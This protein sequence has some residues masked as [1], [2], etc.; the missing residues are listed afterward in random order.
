MLEQ[1]PSQNEPLKPPSNRRVSTRSHNSS[2]Q[3]SLQ[4]RSDQINL[5]GNDHNDDQATNTFAQLRPYLTAS[6]NTRDN[7]SPIIRHQHERL[8][9]TY[10]SKI[11][12]TDEDSKICNVFKD[13]SIEINIQGCNLNRNNDECEDPVTLIVA[14]SLS[15]MSELID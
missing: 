13:L 3:S 15:S 9:G 1:S 12:I 5:R 14:T 8:N 6:I 11:N 2:L 7:D 10:G 4:I